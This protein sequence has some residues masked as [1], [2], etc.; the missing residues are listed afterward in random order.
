[1]VTV[2]LLATCDNLGILSQFVNILL[3][4][5]CNLTIS[6]RLALPERDKPSKG[7]GQQTSQFCYKLVIPKSMCD[8]RE[9]LKLM[10]RIVI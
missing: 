1:M 3:S 5:S 10:A 7:G 8:K 2:T 9:R 4:P 6:L